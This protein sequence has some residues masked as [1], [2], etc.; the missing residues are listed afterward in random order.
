MPIGAPGEFVYQPVKIGARDGR[1]YAE[2]SPDIYTLMPGM[3]TEARRIVEQL[4]WQNAVDWKKLQRVVEE[5]NGI[6]V[7][8]TLGGMPV[9]PKDG[10]RGPD[11]AGSHRDTL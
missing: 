3:F 2:V 5:Q 9:Q 6:P 4:G 8:V 10:K 7:D 11:V 1:I